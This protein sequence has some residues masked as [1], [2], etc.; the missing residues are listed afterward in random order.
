MT[1]VLGG[2]QAHF[3]RE[4]YDVYYRSLTNWALGITRVEASFYQ[5]ETLL[6]GALENIF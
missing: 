2:C 6:V 3:L 5:R 1:H 4:I